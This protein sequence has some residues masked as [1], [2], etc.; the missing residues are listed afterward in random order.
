[1]PDGIKLRKYVVSFFAIVRSVESAGRSTRYIGLTHKFRT[2]SEKAPVVRTGSFV[3]S[4]GIMLR[5]TQS[6]CNLD[7]KATVK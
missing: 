1:M 4:Q 7:A 6:E 3:R 5:Y 2:L